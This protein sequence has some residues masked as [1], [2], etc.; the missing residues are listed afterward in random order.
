MLRRFY[1]GAFLLVLFYAEVPWAGLLLEWL[2][3]P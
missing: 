2:R 3:S 1:I